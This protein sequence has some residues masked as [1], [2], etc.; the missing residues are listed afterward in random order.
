[1]SHVRL[2]GGGSH[3]KSWPRKQ[4]AATRMS[5]N[6]AAESQTSPCKLCPL[7]QAT[8]P[9]WSFLSSV[10]WDS[11]A[12]HFLEQL[13]RLGEA[14]CM[15]GVWRHLV[16]R[17]ALFLWTH[18]PPG[19]PVQGL[20]L[21]EGRPHHPPT[22]QQL[23][24]RVWAAAAASAGPPGTLAEQVPWPS[25][26]ASPSCLTTRSWSLGIQAPPSRHPIP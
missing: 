25:S 5:I 16:N 3:R 10:K 26:G 4:N 23:R 24:P 22:G 6:S 13:Q 8:D 7:G 18:H 9:L 21:W 1:M 2:R 20:S 14:I 19:A 15:K 11:N 12:V 17:L